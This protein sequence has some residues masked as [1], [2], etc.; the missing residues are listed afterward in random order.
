MTQPYEE[1][2]QIAAMTL[3]TIDPVGSPCAAPVYFVA[4]EQSLNQGITGWRLYFFSVPDSQH[5]QNITREAQA[6]AAIYPECRGWQDIRGLQLRGQVKSVA[7][8]HEWEVAWRA[9]CAKFPFVGE[10]KPIVARNELY[11]FTPEWIRLVDNRRG[12]GFKQEWVFP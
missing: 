6:A 8:G 4:R 1:L 5:A 12:F 3:S 2:F 10:L 7:Q 9:Y 11:A